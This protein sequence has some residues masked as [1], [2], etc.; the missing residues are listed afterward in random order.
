MSSKLVAYDMRPPISTCTLSSKIVGSPCL[1]WNEFEIQG[2][3]CPFDRPELGGGGRIGGVP[4]GADATGFRNRNAQQLEPFGHDVGDLNADSGY[5]PARPRERRDKTETSRIRAASKD[6]RDRL[7]GA[8]R[9]PRRRGA[10]R[11]DDVRL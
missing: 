10:N 7:G 5:V 9:R 1:R 4:E 11:D 3:G 6:D 2:P 8:L